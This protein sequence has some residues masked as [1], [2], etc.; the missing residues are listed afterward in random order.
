MKLACVIHRYGREVVGGSESHCRALAERLADFHDVTVLTSCATDYLTWRDVYPA[1]ASTV[2][3]VRV[4]RFPAARQRRLHRLA[5]M[6][7][8]VCGPG[9]S[10]DEEEAWFR[11]NGPDLPGLLEHLRT[12]GEHYDRILFWAYRYAPTF[13][14]LPLVR[15]RAI[16]VPTA[17]EDPIIRLRLLS[18]YFTLPRGYLFLTPEEQE[19]IAQ[20]VPGRLPP[21]TVIGTGLEPAPSRIDSSMLPSLGVT[22]PFVLYLG[23]VDVNKGC[24]AL[25]RDF[26]TFVQREGPRVQLVLAGPVFMPL[27]DHPSILKLGFVDDAVR[28]A[29]LASA[30]ALIVP[31]P[32]ESL[33]IALLEGWNH[34]RPA[35]VNGRCRVLAGQVLR[36]GGGL[37]Y[38]HVNEFVAGLRE[39]LDREDLARQLGRQGL[40]YVD[41]DYRWPIVIERVRRFLEERGVRASTELAEQCQSH[42]TV[43]Q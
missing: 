41:R 19:L 32:Y 22:S 13:F 31:S 38:R 30:R 29:L 12:D 35:L 15:E 20:K 18:A 21:S 16:L 24:E 8:L 33:S 10:L 26:E 34:G 1:G 17:E 28:E 27:P 4:L 25:L 5:E 14:G 42:R 40:A 9:A 7:D 11:E 23:R 36:A 6:T 43:Q 37:Y 2:G 39:L 3:P